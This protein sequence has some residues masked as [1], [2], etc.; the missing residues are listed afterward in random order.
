MT[1]GA[2]NARSQLEARAWN[3]D[4]RPIEFQAIAPREEGTAT[5]RGVYDKSDDD[6]DPKRQRFQVDVT[7]RDD[8]V[9]E[10][11]HFGRCAQM[12]FDIIDATDEM[13]E[14]FETLDKELDTLDSVKSDEGMDLR[15]LLRLDAPDDDGKPDGVNIV[16]EVEVLVDDVDDDRARIVLAEFDPDIGKGVTH[17]Y[18]S[19][20][21]KVRIKTKKGQCVLKGLAGADVFNNAVRWTG[22]KNGHRRCHVKGQKQKNCYRISKGWK[23]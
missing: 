15:K 5:Y 21:K 23:R 20:R 2:T 14:E 6:V 7:A 19:N 16:V 10:L 18:T 11:E 12:W 3:N 4:V 17:W 9:C 8:H 13:L 22:W 1:M